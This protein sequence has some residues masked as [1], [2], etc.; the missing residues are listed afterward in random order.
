MRRVLFA[1]LFLLTACG[2]SD[3]DRP[4]Q[5]RPMRG[6]GMRQAG[7]MLLD[8]LP[9]DTW[10][11]DNSLA[12][13][14]NLSND[15]FQALDRIAGDQRDEIARLERDLP[16]ATRDL[17]SAL[18]TDPTSAAD[19]T[20]AAQRIRDIRGSL[21]DRQAQMLSAE[22]VVLTQKQW[23]TLL[24]QLQQQRGQRMNR[25]NDGYGGRGGRRGGYPRGGGGRPWPY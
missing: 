6:T 2:S 23:T 17:R 13:A 5:G 25:G 18:N 24:D 9:D 7:P 21:F 10:W 22:R 12:A 19:I 14:L 20:A 1:V 8:V 4:P 15:Q 16:V 11:R 3:Y